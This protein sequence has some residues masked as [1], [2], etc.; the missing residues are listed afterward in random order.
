MGGLIDEAGRRR[1]LSA[2]RQEPHV[3]LRETTNRRWLLSPLGWKRRSLAANP[4]SAIMASQGN[5]YEEGRVYT[6]GFSSAGVFGRCVINLGM[7][8]PM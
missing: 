8:S 7:W 3:L 4:L 6:K 5:G 1:G 2:G